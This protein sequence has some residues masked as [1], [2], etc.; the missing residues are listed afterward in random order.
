MNNVPCK[1][2]GW[3]DASHEDEDCLN[4]TE[5]AQ[6]RLGYKTALKNCRGYTGEIPEGNMDAEKIW[7]KEVA[8][9]ERAGGSL[10][11]T[12]KSHSGVH[13]NYGPKDTKAGKV[14]GF[15]KE[16]GFFR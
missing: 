15:L 16:C 1:H 5:A 12:S 10:V 9:I 11:S 13:I 3:V 6:K 2:C 4:S 7:E 14:E 8:R